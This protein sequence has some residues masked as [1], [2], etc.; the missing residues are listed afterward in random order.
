MYIHPIIKHEQ[1]E[2]EIPA[3]ESP[4]KINFP[5]L[6]NLR[7][8][9][10]MS[11]TAFNSNTIPT[12]VI[13][14]EVIDYALSGGWFVTLQLYNGKQFVNQMPLREF[15]KTYD[16]GKIAQEGSY[17][18]FSREFNFQKINWPKSY[19]EFEPNGYSALGNKRCLLFSVYYS[20]VRSI[21]QSDKKFEFRKKQ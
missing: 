10:L 11:I 13:G 6:P 7:N 18:A 20:D 5:D 12:S 4:L 1:V 19:I 16:F 8:V 3:N 14:T 9:H 2:I 21:E 15:F 17:N